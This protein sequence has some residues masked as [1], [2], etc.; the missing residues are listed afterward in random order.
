M[1]DRESFF[2]LFRS[3]REAGHSDY[4]RSLAADWLARWPGD[5]E[6]QRALAQLEIEQKRFGTAIERLSQVIAR[7]PSDREAYHLLS[8]ALLTSGDPVRAAVYRGCHAALAGE[9]LP[10]SEAATWSQPLAEAV[11]AL[12]AGQ[13]AIALERAQE[14]LLADASLPLPTLIAVRSHQACGDAAS[15]LNLARAGLD[16]WPQT[17]AFRLLVAQDRL[18]QGE[19]DRG[20]EDLHRAAA[21]D[22]T[23][24]LADALLGEDHP[25]R[26]LWPATLTAPLSR[27]QPEPKTAAKAVAAEAEDPRRTEAA[28]TPH[29]EERSPQVRPSST[30]RQLQ[31]RESSDMPQP[32]PWEAYDGPDPGTDSLRPRSLS[33]SLSEIRDEL[34]RLGRR[35]NARRPAGD[36]DARAPAYLVLSSKTRLLQLTEADGYRRVH[37]AAGKLVKAVNKRP[38]WQGYR[39]YIDDPASLKPF[40]LT[41]VDPSNAWQI[42]LRL[43]DL[44]ECL[45]ARGQMIAALMIVGNHE[46]VPFHLLPNPT[47]DEDQ[48][49]PSDNPYATSDENYFAPEWPVGRLPTADPDLLSRQLRSAAEEHRLAAS[50]SQARTGFRAWLA[51]H[52]NRILGRS[53]QAI[54]YTASVWKKASMVVFRSIGEPRRLLSSPPVEAKSLP[55]SALRPSTLSYYNLHGLEDSP[56]WYGQ[57]DPLRDRRGGEEFPIALRVEDVVNSGRAPKIVFTEACYG[58]N[59]IDKTPKTALALRFLDRGSHAVVGSTKVSYGSVMPPLIAADLLGSRFWEN[60]KRRL[61]VGEALRRAKLELAHEMHSRQGYLDGEDQKALISFVLY[62]DP[63][64]APRDVAATAGKKS[65]IRRYRRPTSMKTACSLGGPVVEAA[66]LGTETQERVKSIVSRYLP[67]MEGASCTIHGQHHGCDSDDHWC[68]SHQLGIKGLPQ[69]DDQAM[70]VTL[71]KRIQSGETEHPHY[72]RLT[73][74]REGKVLKL[75]VSR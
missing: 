62:G 68:P 9:A 11:R 66:Q 37:E 73:M 3:A 8:A 19:L 58:A 26:Q 31:A 59:V 56:A 53:P 48:E 13:P 51:A 21:A 65:V 57:R 74:D 15:A 38:G 20:V 5:R 46:I 10:P 12:E 7:D 36:E 45:A 33:D 6:A 39:I 43:A 52:M 18:A 44:D 75:A 27:R 2:D 17:I 63:M 22:P 28:T 1:I 61:P 47:D 60:L 30:G 42:K 16:R 69:R 40:G 54:G 55:T 4:A 49:V 67:G 50:A 71:A 32:E 23:G 29:P 70:V 41:P 64:F 34:Q 25:Y 72:A 24:Q 35:L 14:A